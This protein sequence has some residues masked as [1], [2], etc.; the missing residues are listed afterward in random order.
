M[1]TINLK[2]DLNQKVY[3]I[4]GRTAIDSFYVKKIV[5]KEDEILYIVCD[6]DRQIYSEMETSEFSEEELFATYE[7]AKNNQ[8][9]YLENYMNSEIKR[10]TKLFQETINILKEKKETI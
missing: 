10:I 8:I 3:K 9:A 1:M 2:F 6:D 4:T 7:E 5:I